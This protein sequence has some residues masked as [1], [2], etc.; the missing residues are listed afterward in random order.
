[1]ATELWR[2]SALELAGMIRSGEVSSREVVEAHLTRAEECNAR[3]NAIVE[4]FPDRSVAWADE[5]D[6]ALAAGGAPG[7]LH[8]VPCTIKINLDFAGSA[9]HEGS[10]ALAGLVAKSDAPV[11]ARM[12]AA[13]AVPVGRTNMPDLGLRLSTDSSLFGATHNPWDHD[14]TA[15]GSSG[16][17]AAAIASGLS[18]IGLGNDIGG[19]LRNPAYACGITSIKPGFGRVPMVNPS[20]PLPP[21]LS[22]QLMLVNGVLARR[23]ADVRAGLEIIM[24]SHPSD[25][26]VVDAPL[27][28]PPRPRRIGLVPEPAGGS[29][30][31]GVAEGVRAAGRA[32]EAAGY[33]VEEM[34]PPR[35]EDAYVAWSQLLIGDLGVMRP[36][37]D[38]VVGEGGRRFLD[39]SDPGAQ[40]PDAAATLAMH[41]TRF[42]I[43]VAWQEMFADYGAIVGPTWTQPPFV[44]GFDIESK[45]TALAVL[46]MIR[47]VLPANLLG[48]PAACVPTGVTAGLPVGAQIIAPRLR[49]DVCL[50]LAEVIEGH[51]GIFTPID[52]R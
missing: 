23:V 18:P 7:A 39:L 22:A 34:A 13:G 47:F 27:A 25:P 1:M 50:D 10:D 45:A 52:P 19:S 21:M 20:A 8:G 36:L 17:E 48:L 14:R 43:G 24:G 33:Q 15:A 12:R 6:A 11:V 44:L 26:Q 16:G 46:E 41:Q 38:M 29:T 3:V 30:D 35:L 32:L 42:Q 40:P 2:M 5:A 9:T 49:E 51:L 37:L 31:P 28:G 4:S